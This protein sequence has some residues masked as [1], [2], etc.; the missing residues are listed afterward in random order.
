MNRISDDERRTEAA[1]V[2]ASDGHAVPE[3][4]DPAEARAFAETFAR[5]GLE[6]SAAPPDRL[7]ERLLAAILRPP[8][9]GEI[10]PGVTLLRSGDTAWRNFPFPG[11]RYR[12]LRRSA[13]GELRTLLIEMD[14]GSRFP[15][16]PHD[17]VEEILVLRGVLE[18]SGVV[19][20]AGDYCRSLPGTADHDVFST[21]GALYLVSLTAPETQTV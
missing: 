11:V 18:T 13:S 12:A 14:P 16:H 1:A 4:V 3:G 6:A 5:I 8:A 7:R 10:R 2:A 15:D 9:S 17:L 21:E 20:R 19:L